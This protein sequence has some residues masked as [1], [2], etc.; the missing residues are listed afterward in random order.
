MSDWLFG[1]GSMMWTINQESVLLLGGRGALLMQLAHPLVAAGVADHSDFPAGSFARL[2]RTVDTMMTIIFGTRAEAEA[3][4][5]RLDQIHSR[6]TG[7]APDGRPYSAQD[8]ALKLWVFAT[9]ID[10]SVRVYESC[11]A[12]LSGEEIDRYY[13]ETRTLAHLFDIP[14]EILPGSFAGLRSWMQERIDTGEVH[15]TPLAKEMADHIVRPLRFMPRRVANAASFIT[16]GLLP[17]EIREAY[18]LH[19]GP[20]R[21]FALAAGSRA[22]RLVIPRLPR[23]IRTFPV[24]RF[25]AVTSRRGRG[26]PARSA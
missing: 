19:L 2:R 1:P 13:D 14:D 15:V 23:S 26:A 18:G 17:L 7:V 3:A 8:P 4:G 20:V 21:S 16:A 11:V 10:S 9:L 5:A 12:R 24:T 22:S 25:F 6:V